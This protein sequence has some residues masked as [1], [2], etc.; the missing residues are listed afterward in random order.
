MT[1]E[2]LISNIKLQLLNQRKEGRKEEELTISLFSNIY[3][4]FRSGFSEILTEVDD[5][6]MD[7]KKNIICPY[8]IHFSGVNF[9]ESVWFVNI[10]FTN[11]VQF[12]NVTFNQLTN[13]S[14]STFSREILFSNTT[15]NGKTH[16]NKCTFSGEA[17]FR[18]IKIENTITFENINLNDKNRI[19]FA[20]IN[21]DKESENSKIEIINTVIN[22]RIDFDNVDVNEIDFKGTVVIGA[23]VISTDE[24]NVNKYATWKTARFLKHEAYKISNTIEALKYK[25]IEKE[26]YAK[27][28]IEK[29]DKTLQTWAEIFSLRI[30]KL[31]NNHGQDW[32]RAV[33]FTLISG[34]FFFSLSYLFISNVN[35][36][37]IKYMFTETFIK[38]Y[39]NYLIPTNFELIKNVRENINILFYVLYIAGKISVGYGI[40]EIIQAFRKFNS[41]G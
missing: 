6:K 36:Y 23:G 26:L 16:F 35:I 39:F 8:S 38:N 17:N 41:K 29:T 13:F 25:A 30:S 11:S 3:S 37:N 5:I 34:F 20:N 32:F 12:Y 19:L 21:Y 15:F 1:K 27:E 40:F 33:A 24:L 18:N 2:Q 10:N 7:V 9:I 28:L 22:G 31:S 14:E 4:D